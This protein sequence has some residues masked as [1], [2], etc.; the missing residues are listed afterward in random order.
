MDATFTYFD[1][2]PSVTAISIPAGQLRVGFFFSDALSFEPSFGLERIAS[3]DASLTAWSAEAGLLWHFNP[4]SAGTVVYAR[5]FVGIT[6]ISADADGEGEDE[7]D[8]TAGIG[9]GLKTP[10]MLGNRFRWRFEVG[11]ARQFSNPDDVNAYGA[12]I[13]LSFFT[14]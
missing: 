10:L 11:Y 1:T 9:I 8:P 5:P 2:D 6:G 14:R 3:D 13:G 12:A 7:T 4:A